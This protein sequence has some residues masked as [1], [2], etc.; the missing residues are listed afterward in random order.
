MTTIAIKDKLI[1]R[2]FAP[3]I[4]SF[5]IILSI[6]SFYIS[7]ITRDNAIDTAISSAEL[8]VKQYKIIRGYYT[9]NI[10]KKILPIADISADYSHKDDP[11][12]IPL[13]ATLIHEIG[14][15]LTKKGIVTLKL[16]S[17]YPFPNRSNRK[18]DSFEQKAW[19][20]LNNNSEQS[21]SQI[22]TINDKQVVRVAL[23]DTMTQQGCV[24]CH[25]SH[26]DTPKNDW[27]LN[28]VRGVLEVQVP[29]EQ[30]LSSA[31]QLNNT[32]IL[33]MIVSLIFII[34]LLFIMFK[35]LISER[36]QKVYFALEEIAQE[37]GDLSQRLDETSK[38]EVGSIA[39]AFNYF[40]SQLEKTLLGI[41]KQVEQ[42]SQTT[43]S[44]TAITDETK[45]GALNQQN[46]ADQ[47]A[48]AMNDMKSS[49]QEMAEIAVSTA[50]NSQKAQDHSVQSQGTIVQS[51]ESIEQL[52]TMIKQAADV[53]DK[54]D[55]DS[56]NIGGVLDVIR[57]ISDQTNLL[58]LNAAIEAAR[59]GEHG[60]G[61]AVVADEVRTL[62]G[63]TQQSTEE[64]NTMIIQLQTGA[65]NAVNT[66]Q[67]GDESIE[68]SNAKTNEVNVIIEEMNNVINHIQ[69]QNLQLATA[70]EQQAAV[71]N[72]INNNIDT[73]RNVS[74]HTSE[75]SQQLLIMAEEINNSVNVINKQLQRFTKGG[76]K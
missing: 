48:S 54:L 28:D 20:A 63:R 50:G 13:P 9:K 53:V 35:K 36:L 69:A 74:T 33:I 41:N 68:I 75:N 15:T 66:I 52:S 5:L 6:L 72:E 39:K 30:Q 18:L 71:S 14:E 3:L 59:A 56:Q 27:R 10:I 12:K 65:K 38:D 67:Q 61:F 16:Y 1:T 47:V 37:E 58:A 24:N 23:A 51:M 46:L 29:I 73:I 7:S 45:S 64:I 62:A 43:Q 40:I 42:L 21:F 25:N 49:T 26:P 2:L 31:N 4:I 11:N 34:A 60:R 55:S 57:S 17:P 8:T 44:M 32:I 22:E 19:E 70:A 76:S